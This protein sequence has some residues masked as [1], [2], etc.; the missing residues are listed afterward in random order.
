ME[1]LLQ[2]NMPWIDEYWE[3]IVNKL[4]KTTEIAKYKLP[5]KLV[6]GKYDDHSKGTAAAWTNGFWP[7]IN[8][9]MYNATGEETFRETAEIGEKLLD[10]A[11][12]YYNELH[13]DVGFMWLLS[14][15]ANY[16]LTG[17]EAAKNKTL[18]TAAIL[19]ARYNTAGKFIKAWPGEHAGYVIIDCMMNIPLLFWAAKE[20]DNVAFK[21]M[22]MDHADTTIKNHIRDDGSVYH[23]IDY[24]FHT[25]ECL[26][27]AVHG[28]GYDPNNSSW[29]RG[30]SWAV[31]GYA[32]AYMHTGEK[33]YLDVAK[34]VAHYF[35]AAAASN[36]WAV[37]SDF[38][39]PD[40]TQLDSSA[41]AVA[42]CGMIEI[43]KV[44]PDF[45]K[46]LYMSAALKLIKKVLDEQCDFTDENEGIVIYSTGSYDQNVH[47]GYIF[48]DYYLIEA[49]CKLKGI[50]PMFW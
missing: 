23:I 36:D 15:G 1:K 3:K 41:A 46:K 30:Q 8:W 4:R 11:L 18:I 27:P 14:S 24:N 50:D 33:R 35:I 45:E 22:A 39:A 31:Y 38:R 13:H 47:V 5:L 2:E 10:T 25:G 29:T 43:A 9:L 40:E 21:Q 17:N 34:K 7:G 28:Q 32:L 20:A 16:R 44:V 49:M 26:G 42:A 48:G 19:A 6:N 12:N 37:R